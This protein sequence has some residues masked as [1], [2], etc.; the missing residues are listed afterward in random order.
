MNV[1]DITGVYCMQSES[2]RTVLV[3]GVTKELDSEQLELYFE[4]KGRS[5]GGPVHEVVMHGSHDA[6]VTFVDPQ[7][8]YT[9]HSGVY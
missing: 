5:G 4:N 1:H 6:L 8:T 7:G 9:S 2:A 3:G